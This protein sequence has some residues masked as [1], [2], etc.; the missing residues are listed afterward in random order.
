MLGLSFSTFCRHRAGA[1][2]SSGTCCGG[3]RPAMDDVAGRSERAQRAAPA[4]L[5]R[6]AL[7]A[8]KLLADTVLTQMPGS[9]PLPRGVAERA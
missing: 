4:L 6:A 5:A 1:W 3:R 7:S 2:L 8:R 9:S